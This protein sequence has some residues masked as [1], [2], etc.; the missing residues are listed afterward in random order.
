MC[1][2][3]DCSVIT[4][5]TGCS[6]NTVPPWPEKMSNVIV[7]SML[8]VERCIQGDL[9]EPIILIVKCIFWTWLIIFYMYVYVCKSGLMDI[10]EKG[11]PVASF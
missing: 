6:M 1:E 8:Y 3:A 4:V 5:S 9:F 10:G 11:L 2:W 7:K